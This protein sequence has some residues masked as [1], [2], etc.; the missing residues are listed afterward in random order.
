MFGNVSRSRLLPMSLPFRYFG[1]AAGFQLMAWAVLLLAFRDFISF[2]AGLGPVFGALHLVTL[3]VLAMSAIGATLQLLPVATRQPVRAL[4]AVK[5]VWWLL[6]PGTLVFAL[7]AALYRPQTMALGAMAIV[8]AFAIYGGL[9]FKNLV[10][11]RGMKVVVAHGWAALAC[12]LGLAATGLAVV[13][14][15][16]HGW[17]LDHAALRSAHLVLASYGFMGLLSFGLS[18]FLLPMLAVAPPPSALTIKAILGTSITALLLGSLGFVLPAAL[19]GLA[20]AAAHVIAME[21]SLRARLRQPLGASFL[22]VRVSWACLLASL[23]LAAL[24]AL[25]LA[26][27]RAPLLFG[28]LLVPGWLLTF[29]LGVLQRIVPFLASVHASS[30]TR[31]TPVISALT[32]VRLLASHRVLHLLALSLLLAAA[33]TGSPWLSLAGAAAGLAGAVAFAAFF[34]FVLMKVHHGIQ[35]PHQPATA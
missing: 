31:G 23:A 27:P 1:A 15:Y 29:L 30:S 25:D 2:E 21:R 16:E 28:L 8:I 32:P 34:A 14:R 11:A 20:A 18:T 13:G 9:L 19:L 4:W 12:L 22:L 35:P 10:G 5:L 26:P 17:A 7:G 6:V 24:M 33:A 3:G